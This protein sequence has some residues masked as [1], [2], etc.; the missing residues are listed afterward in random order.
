[1]DF[2]SSGASRFFLGANTRRGF[3]SYYD[4]FPGF[5]G[6]DFLWVI[7]GG[8]GC[9]KSSF[10]KR[11]GAAAEA[12]GMPVEYIHCSGD[13][14]SLDAVYLPLQH[15][16]YADGTAPHVIEAV[17]PG[18]ASLYLDL[19]SFLDA[20][21]LKPHLEEIA[22]LN[23]EYKAL[24]AGAY[25][26]LSAAAALLPSALPGC[27]PPE[28]SARLERRLA[29]LV[30]RELHALHKEGRLRHR[31]LSANSCQG[32]ITLYDTLRSGGYRLVT[33][34]NRLGLGH[35]FLSGL[36]EQAL[37][38]GYEVILC[39][40]PLEPELPE[41]VLLPEAGL[42]LLAADRPLPPELE[43]YR[44]LRLDALAG[45]P[46]AALRTLLRRRKKESDLLLNAA[47]D[48]LARAKVLHD[49]LEAVYHP[50][51]DFAG[52]AALSE[53]HIHWLFG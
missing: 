25:A 31:L 28:A 11:I 22:A 30:S 19:G 44:H 33:L 16:A 49:R 27:V 36:T 34:D 35:R 41:A 24:Y 42:A 40:D 3:V 1:M 53:D 8:P 46:D 13:P 47:F 9:G 29:G 50:H 43:I 48:T 21:A 6:E 20:D 15:V 37:A 39:H 52:S 14:D 10:M 32:R 26:Q 5:S 18:A 4:D 45:T 51:V 23:R 17:Y 38:R 2:S 7:K 12:A